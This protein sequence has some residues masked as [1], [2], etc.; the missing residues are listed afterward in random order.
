MILLC[1]TFCQF[2][3]IKISNRVNRI[4][5][6]LMP[7]HICVWGFTKI[8]SNMCA[9]VCVCHS[10]GKRTDIF[11]NFYYKTCILTRVEIKIQNPLTTYI[12]IIQ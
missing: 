4:T 3:T 2:N 5:A 1:H 8:A 9:R 12:Y 6:N 10:F 7:T 11:L